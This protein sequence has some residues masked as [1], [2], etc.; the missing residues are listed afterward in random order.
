MKK[1]IL[2]N[3]HWR[4][5]EIELICLNENSSHRI[6]RKLHLNLKFKRQRVNDLLMISNMKI[7][8]KKLWKS[9]QKMSMLK[10]LSIDLNFK[11]V[12]FHRLSMHLNKRL[13]LY[14]KFFRNQKIN[15]LKLIRNFEEL[16]LICNLLKN[17]I[18]LCLKNTNSYLTIWPKD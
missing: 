8:E 12:N 6:K 5:F 7:F 4:V 11:T 10:L 2:S 13:Q 16:N 14:S 9:D 3:S 15:H 1:K 18:K 17:P